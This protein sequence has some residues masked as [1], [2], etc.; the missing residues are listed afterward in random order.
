MQNNILFS[1]FLIIFVVLVVAGCAEHNFVPGSPMAKMAGYNRSYEEIAADDCYTKYGFAKGS[2]IHKKCIYEL[3]MARRQSDN[4]Y[5][6]A[7]SRMAVITSAIANPPRTQYN[8][9]GEIA[10][11]FKIGE[12]QAGFNKI[13]LYNDLGSTVAITIG[14]TQM[15][16]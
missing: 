2:N 9:G 6:A 8:S 14:S 4:A 11:G 10:R 7:A 3:S 1:V 16:P 12:Y 5:M 13:C 15:C